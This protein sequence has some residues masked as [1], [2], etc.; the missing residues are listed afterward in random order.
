MM[1]EYGWVKSHFICC[2]AQ[3]MMYLDNRP[4]IGV[5]SIQRKKKRIAYQN[6]SDCVLLGTR[7]TH[8]PAIKVYVMAVGMV[9]VSGGACRKQSTFTAPPENGISAR[10]SKETGSAGRMNFHFSPFGTPHTSHIPFPVTL[11]PQSSEV[12]KHDAMLNMLELWIINQIYYRKMT[13]NR[14]R[15]RPTMTTSTTPATR[16]A[17]KEQQT[18]PHGNGKWQAFT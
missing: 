4:K 3:A 14:K 11:E 9:A 7:V 15:V 16:E 13:A 18:N 2:Q 8:Y 12:Y 10:R 6:E 1:N 17:E 5:S